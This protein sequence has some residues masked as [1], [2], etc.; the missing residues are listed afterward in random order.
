MWPTV[1]K[2]HHPLEQLWLLQYS[3]FQMAK[4]FLWP[5][6]MDRC[7]VH[8]WSTN[9][10]AIQCLT[11]K[12]TFTKVKHNANQRHCS[13]SLWAVRL[14]TYC[15]PVY[16]SQP[17]EQLDCC[18]TPSS[19]W[20]RQWLKYQLVQVY[21][22]YSPCD[23]QLCMNKNKTCTWICYKTGKFKQVYRKLKVDIAMV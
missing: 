7:K 15:W 19:K 18:N 3:K 8:V 14:I 11:G 17:L 13:V 22:T 6:T 4:A 12:F 23:S 21:N 10:R 16:H 20:Q 1:C 5:P 2:F 9:E